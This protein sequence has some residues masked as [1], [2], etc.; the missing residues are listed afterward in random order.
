MRSLIISATRVAPNIR[1]QFFRSQLG[2]ALV[3]R[4]RKDFC[5]VDRRRRPNRC[6]DWEQQHDCQNV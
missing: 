2:S 1:T 4:E 3:D 5:S 6:N